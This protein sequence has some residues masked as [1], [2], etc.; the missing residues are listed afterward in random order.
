MSFEEEAMTNQTLCEAREMCEDGMHENNAG[1]PLGPLAHN[2]YGFEGLR[3]RAP[4]IMTQL[5]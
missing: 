3:K 4:R 5:S 2:S 1:G